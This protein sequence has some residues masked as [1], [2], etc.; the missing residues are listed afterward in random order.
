MIIR[1]LEVD[2]MDNFCYLVGCGKTRKAM[3]IDPGADV[4][5]I[6]A[7]FYLLGALIVIGAEYDQVPAAISLIVSDAFTGTAATGGFVGSTFIIRWF[8]GS[9]GVCSLTRPGRAPHRSPMPQPGQNTRQ[10][11]VLWHPW[12]H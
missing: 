5:R 11:K 9:E 7:I 1:Q 6:M 8:G 12:N 10:G 3:M 2:H 4:E